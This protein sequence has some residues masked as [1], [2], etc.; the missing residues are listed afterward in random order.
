MAKETIEKVPKMYSYWSEEDI[1]KFIK[2]A[3]ERVNGK[4][5]KHSN[6]GYTATEEQVRREYILSL[7]T[8]GMTKIK[9]RGYLR[10]VF[11]IANSTAYDWV[12]DA[13]YYMTSDKEEMKEYYLNVAR[14]RLTDI[15]DKAMANNEKKVA[16]QA[17][18]E[19]NKING[20]HVEKVEI[21]KEPVLTFKFGNN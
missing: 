21:N 15:Y 11:G 3:K 18:T 16:I 7:F 9:V 20:L 5:K 6:I 13:I 17:Q 14:E 19:L 12:D 10:E 8:K 4:G 2:D 1:I